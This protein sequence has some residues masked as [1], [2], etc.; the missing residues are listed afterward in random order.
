MSTRTVAARVLDLSEIAV[1]DREAGWTF[2]RLLAE[3]D[4][5]LRHFPADR[6]GPPSLC[7]AEEEFRRHPVGVVG[8]L[9]GDTQARFPEMAFNV[10]RSYRVLLSTLGMTVDHHGWL[11]SHRAE[12]SFPELTVARL[13]PLMPRVLRCLWLLELRGYS[14]SGYRDGHGYNYARSLADKLVDVLKLS[15][16]RGVLANECAAIRALT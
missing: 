11:F 13:E 3:P 7:V 10:L 14:N 2:E 8:Y 9:D 16:R 15:G 12:G 6:H 1:L 4:V 5:V